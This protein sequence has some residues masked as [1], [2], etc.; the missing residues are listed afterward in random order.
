MHELETESHVV[1]LESL[2][3]S[4]SD[5][6]AIKT[7]PAITTIGNPA[8]L[9]LNQ[10][11]PHLKDLFFTDVTRKWVLEVDMLLGSE[12][13]IE[14]QTGCIRTGERGEPVA[15]L[16]KSSRTLMGSTSTTQVVH[17]KAPESSILIV[18]Q[19]QMK[20]VVSNEGKCT[21]P[22]QR[23]EEKCRVPANIRLTEGRFEDYP[24]ILKGQVANENLS[25]LGMRGGAAANLQRR[26]EWWK[27]QKS[28]Q[29]KTEDWPTPPGHLKPS[30]EEAEVQEKASTLIFKIGANT[31]TRIQ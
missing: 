29:G 11:Y 30:K 15:V 1:R 12:H 5:D 23:R 4:Y 24:E 18:D 3:N 10:L 16:T 21:V 7:L 17:E 14:L 26:K 9:K 22:L 20:G 2:D 6:S 19:M 27:G 8:P 13:L 28:R 31:Q 25:N